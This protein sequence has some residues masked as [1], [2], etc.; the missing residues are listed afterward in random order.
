MSIDALPNNS[1]ISRA[2]LAALHDDAWRWCYFMMQADRDATDEVL[3][4]VYVLIIEGRAR[5]DGRSSLKTWLYGVIRNSTKR[6]LRRRLRERLLGWWD[7]PAEHPESVALDWPT[8]ADE[9]LSATL[10]QAIEQLPQ[11]QKD[12]LA[13]TVLRDFS[14]RE[15]AKILGISIGSARTHY[16]RA[17][18]ALRKSLTELGLHDV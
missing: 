11:R 5:Y 8:A 3:Q 17:K 14:L 9:P 6:H 16:H 1:R 15:C 10:H 12:V 7:T 18:S 13:L 4:N 2:E